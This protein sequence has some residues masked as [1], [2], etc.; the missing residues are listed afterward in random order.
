MARIGRESIEIRTLDGIY[1]EICGEEATG[2]YLKIDA[3]G[4]EA[5]VLSG[6]ASCLK[7]IDTVQLEMSLQRLYQGEYT[8]IDMHKSMLDKGYAMVSI[9]PVFF[10]A[11]SGKLLQVDGTYQRI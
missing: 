5:K 3:Q 4:Y 6:A 11:S 1:D 8:F 9:E 7:H 2:I 10:D